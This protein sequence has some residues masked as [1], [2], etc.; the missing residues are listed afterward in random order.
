MGIDAAV[1]NEE[2]LRKSIQLKFFDGHCRIEAEYIMINQTD[3]DLTIE[4]SFNS[5]RMLNPICE[6]GLKQQLP[7]T[8]W[9]FSL[10]HTKKRKLGDESPPARRRRL[11]Q[12]D[13][14]SRFNDE[15]PAVGDGELEQTLP[16]SLYTCS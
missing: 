7:S 3:K 9:N 5:Q 11:P 2:E 12:R 13:C 15:P 4:V 6:G 10:H 14:Q 1:F 16:S 8:G